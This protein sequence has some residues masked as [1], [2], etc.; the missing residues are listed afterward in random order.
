M[1][2]WYSNLDLNLTIKL[3]VPSLLGQVFVSYSPFSISPQWETFLLSPSVIHTVLLASALATSPVSLLPLPLLV[4]CSPPQKVT[5]R[6]ISN[7][8]RWEGEPLIAYPVGVLLTTQKLKLYH[9]INVHVPVQ[10]VRF[11]PCL[12]ENINFQHVQ[13]RSGVSC[14]VVHVLY[15]CNV[16]F[17]CDQT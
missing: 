15:M 7:N 1:H 2:N 13:S 10:Y 4:Y 9:P 8:C 16:S 14:R 6:V 12:D 17:G 5:M 3:R 11:V